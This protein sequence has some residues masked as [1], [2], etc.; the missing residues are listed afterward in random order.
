MAEEEAACI[1]CPVRPVNPFESFLALSQTFECENLRES[2]AYE[3]ASVGIVERLLEGKI[4]GARMVEVEGL[5]V[6]SVDGR[7]TV[8]ARCNA[9]R[10]TGAMRH[11]P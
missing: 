4:L 5:V 6:S 3:E 1:T 10:S 8:V 7:Y 2:S 11:S 9:R